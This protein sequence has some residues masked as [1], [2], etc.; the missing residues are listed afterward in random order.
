METRTGHSHDKHD[1]QQADYAASWVAKNE[2]R[3]ER[4]GAVLDRMMA[5]APYPKDRALRVLDVG[6][7]YGFVSAAVLRAFPKAE[8]TL[9]D[10][11]APMIAEAKR[12][13]SSHAAQM[14]FV[15]SDLT[16]PAW[17][18]GLGPFDL[19]VSAIAIH[20]IRKIEAMQACYRAIRD[21]LVPGGWFLDC[22]HLD[23]AGGPD[24][25]AAMMRDVGFASVAILPGDDADTPILKAQA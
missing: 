9:Q 2:G 8:V 4:R 13:L 1:W 12:Y 5:L 18:A 14:R 17:A 21:L 7:G 10:F 25:H 19:V 6:G 20:N 16:D 23:K 3:V 15:Q 24:K 11:S 22:D